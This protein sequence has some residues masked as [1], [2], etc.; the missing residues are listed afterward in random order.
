MLSR[1]V[2]SFCRN[3]RVRHSFDLSLGRIWL[4]LNSRKKSASIEQFLDRRKFSLWKWFFDK[5]FDHSC[6][7]YE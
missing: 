5:T 4:I 3:I 1:F 6:T 7:Y 2:I